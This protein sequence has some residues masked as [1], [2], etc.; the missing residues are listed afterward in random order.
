METVQMSREEIAARTGR[1]AALQPME[2]M[3]NDT[4]V[5]QAAKDI[6]LA[7][8]ADAGGAGADPVRLRQRRADLQRG[9]AHHVH[10]ETFIVLGGTL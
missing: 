10:L 3:K 5:S 1:F 6:I 4:T 8:R 7:R 9:R 2:F